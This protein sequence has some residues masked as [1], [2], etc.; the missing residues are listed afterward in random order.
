[1]I[2]LEDLALKAGVSHSTVSRALADSPLVN[3]ATK[4]RIQN[5][6]QEAGYQVNQVAR[7]L[8]VRTTKTIGLVVPEVSNPFYP[9][10][11]QQV[12]D[13][14]KLAGY[15]LQLHLSAADQESESAC[16]ASLAGNRADGILL[17]TGERGLIARSQVNSLVASGTPVVIMGWVEDAE[18]LDLVAGD[19]AAGGR[20]LAYHLADLGHKRIVVLGKPPHRGVLDRMVGF[21]EALTE[22]GIPLL[23]EMVIEVASEEEVRI[24]VSDLLKLPEPPTAIFAYQDSLAAVVY[25]QLEKEGL[26]IPNDMTVVGFDNLDL[27]TYLSPELTTVGTH[28]SPLTSAFVSLLVARIQGTYPD[29]TPQSIIVTPRLVVRASS[30]PPRSQLNLTDSIS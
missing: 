11:I 12:A 13:R 16:I 26:S 22:R 30:A 4:A 10:L 5:L 24:G 8:K 25:R 7:N 1:V 19:D 20:E 23:P 27:A 3:P 9:E 18:H 6:A 2:T 29:P 21:S 17:V 15:S 14:A 28:I